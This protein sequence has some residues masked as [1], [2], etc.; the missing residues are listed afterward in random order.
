VPN[1]RVLTTTQAA[2]RRT[3]AIWLV[4][5][6]VLGWV[7]DGFSR[8]VFAKLLLVAVAC[9]L[10][11]TVPPLGRLPRTLLILVAA[12]LGVLV[13]AA[14]VSDT[15]T[16]SLLG[17]WPR[18]EG[19]PVLCLYVAGAWLG[20]R[21]LTPRTDDLRVVVD[22]MAAMA[23][24]LGLTSLLDAI[25]ISPLG[26]SLQARDGALLGNATDQGLVAMM[27]VA[28]LTPAVLR[29][30]AP[31]LVAGLIAALATVAVSG[32]R[33]AVI[34][35]VLVVVAVV[36]VVVRAMVR[37]LARRQGDPRLPA[38]MLAVSL[39]CAV[40]VVAAVAVVAVPQSRDRLF[41]T[42]PLRT[43]WRQWEQTLEAARDQPLLGVGPSGYLDVFGRYETAAFA[44]ATGP[45]DLA[46]SPNSWPLQALM[47]G[48][49][50]LLLLALAVAV[51]VLAR[52][53]G[54]LRESPDHLG[55]F[56]AVLGYG[57]ALLFGFTA[58][59]PACLAAFL[60]G[61][62]LGEP[63]TRVPRPWQGYVGTGASA[64]ACVVAL[65]AVAGERDVGA[66]VRAAAAGDVDEAVAAFDSARAWRPWD[67]DLD[68]IAARAL[69]DEAS[70]GDGR[71]A[72]ATER[73]ATLSLRRTPDTYQSQ[74]ALGV[75]LLTQGRPGDAETVLAGA[76]AD[77][78]QRPAAFIQ[79]GLARFGG[80]DVEGAREDLSRAV[81]LDPRN[82]STLRI[83]RA[84]ERHVG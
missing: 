76:V 18:Y 21:L 73:Y 62:L 64:L 63:L 46:D 17:R 32:S 41:A 31:Y 43:R 38:G 39:G 22:P 13:A 57:V 36:A 24:V 42:G 45:Y 48:G 65:G 50:L 77:A 30:R 33:T 51:Y 23:L 79:R 35:T 25:G 58:A 6:S 56:A 34:V 49:P 12:G 1:F 28:V 15:P 19:L 4:C 55:V 3:A 8:F 54:V 61:V 81:E 67:V 47:A 69:A 2:R 9:L 14:V 66:G 40:C 29:H 70:A 82:R 75:A 74:V 53:R 71:A 44:R 20:A 37:A 26:E 60:T 59:G 16:A 72:W 7:P 84:I 52:G 68:M 27:A 78:P 11:A 10:A 83:L 5:F 80:F